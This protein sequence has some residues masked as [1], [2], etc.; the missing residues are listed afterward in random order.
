MPRRHKRKK[1]RFPKFFEEVLGPMAAVDVSGELEPDEQEAIIDPGVRTVGDVP[2]TTGFPGWALLADDEP[3]GLVTEIDVPFPEDVSEGAGGGEGPAPSGMFTEDESAGADAIAH[4]KPW[5]VWGDDWGIYFFAEPFRDFVAATAQLSGGA[6]G[7]FEPFVMGQIL[8]HELTHFEFEVIGTKLEAIHGRP[9]YRSYLFH[10][11]STL[12]R[13]TGPPW[14]RGPHPGPTEE[15]IATWREVYYARRKKPTPPRGYQAAASKLAD[16]AP[17]GYNS[18]RCADT[19]NAHLAGI[20]TATVASLIAGQPQII[21]PAHELDA[22]DLGD[23]PVYWRGDPALIPATA[24]PKDF[25]R[26]NP[27]RLET[28]LKKNKAE[29]QHDRGK[30]SHV[31]FTWRGLSGGFS[32]SRDP[33]PKAPCQEIATIF[34]FTNLR[35]FYLAIASNRVVS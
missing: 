4:Y 33:V 34:G 13:W 1:K 18:W 32:T 35:D 17:A 31:R 6:Y 14:A 28:W 8:E 12:T 30:G 25:T 19:G 5:H 16:A 22:E 21:P 2:P 29:I 7:L 23:V 3:T 20:V 15:A 26:P 10:R 24:P 9:L 27:A 11:Y